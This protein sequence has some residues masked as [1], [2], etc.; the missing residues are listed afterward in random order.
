MDIV[1]NYNLRNLSYWKIGGTAKLYIKIYNVQEYRSAILLAKK[2]NVCPIV[3]GKTSNLLF[4]DGLLNIAVIELGGDFLNIE[5]SKNR[6]IVGAA[7]SSQKLVRFSHANSLSGLEHIIGIPATV[8][9]LVYMNGGSNRQT[10]SEKVVSVE[11]L[12]AHGRLVIRSAEECTFSYRKSIFQENNELISKVIVELLPTSNINDKRRECINI[13]ASR[14]RKFPRKLPSCGSVFISY[15][16]MYD[17]LGPPGKII[18]ELGMK[19]VKVGDAEISPT[20]ANFIVNNGNANANDVLDLIKL[21]NSEV[22]KKFG[23]TLESEAI[24]ISKYGEIKQLHD[25][26]KN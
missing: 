14:R 25:A 15:P 21:I 17:N 16:E 8:G 5:K 24:F 23:F 22:E 12:D 4:D 9:G 11:S 7:A 13:L 19:G 2:N 6:V 20:H 3:I 1:E 26:V 18:E 10:V